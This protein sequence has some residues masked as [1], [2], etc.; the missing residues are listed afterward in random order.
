MKYL[1]LSFNRLINLTGCDIFK[2]IYEIN[3]SNNYLADDQLIHLNQ[4]T[5]LKYLNLSN[6]NLK[7]NAITSNI[8]HL[9]EL[10]VN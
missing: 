8:T 5:L 9:R 7:S 3:L 2:N 1:D 6:N 4:L 10:E